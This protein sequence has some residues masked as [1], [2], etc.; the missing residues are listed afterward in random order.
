MDAYQKAMSLKPMLQHIGS[1]RVKPRSIHALAIAYYDS[2]AFNALKPI[3]QGVYRIIIER[4]CR[5]TDGDGS[6]N[7]DKSVVTMNSRNVE[8]LM[9]ARTAKP[10]SANGLRKVLREMMKVAVKLEWRDT[11]PTLGVKKIKPKKL[12]GF[13]RWFDAEIAQ[14]EARHPVGSRARLAMALGLYTGQARQ[15]VVL[16]GEQ[17]I[18]R[19][20]DPELD[21]EIEVLNWVRKKTEDKT[22]L[23]LAIPVHP[24]LRRIIDAT[25][26]KHLTFLVTE[27]GAPFTVAGFGGWFRDC[28][29]EAGLR[30]CSFHGLRKAAATRLIDAGCDVVEAAA[31]TG[32]A[33]LKE[34]QRYIETRD[35]KKAARRAMAKLVMVK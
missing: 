1:D 32:H 35:R 19:E 23:E 25:P 26:S 15:D 34:L 27:L 5:E 3:T 7:G 4:F 24:E 18:T 9:E 11:D 10:D 20:Y 17:Y 28:C 30:H 22:G 13:H 33:S 8:Q 2:A 14:F 29:N 21:R 12:G 16:M 6:P 31:I